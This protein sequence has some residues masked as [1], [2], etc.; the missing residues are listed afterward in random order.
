MID[1]FEQWWLELLE[2]AR[3]KA[4]EDRNPF[5]AEYFELKA[6]NDKIRLSASKDLL[7]IFLDEAESIQEASLSIDI[8]PWHRFQMYQA[9]LTGF[10][11]IISFGIR[12]LT[13]EIGWTRL[14]KDGF[15]R[16]NALAYC[17]IAH[18]GRDKRQELFLIDRDSP[19]WVLA[20][21]GKEFD[22]SFIRHHFDLLLKA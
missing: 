20:E 21:D 10:C 9:V 16:G 8:K 22:V 5:L 17:R 13:V 18:R 12:Q 7:K 14:P 6:R 15:M 2:K 4:L 1:D 3:Y 19:K 11:L